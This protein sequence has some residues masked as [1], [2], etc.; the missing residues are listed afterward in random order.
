M[1]P[2][3]RR[4]GYA[5]LWTTVVMACFAV[6]AAAAAPY[7]KAG[8]DLVRYQKT[9]EYIH[10]MMTAAADFETAVSDGAKKPLHNYPGRI[11]QFTHP[12]DS[13]SP[14]SCWNAMTTNGK[15]NDSTTWQSAA[16]FVPFWVPSAGLWTPIG[17][18]RD[19]IP[20]RGSSPNS[21][22]LYVDIEGVTA[23][24]ATGFDMYIDSE[25][26]DTVDVLHPPVNDT[27]TLRIR[28]I[29]TAD[30]NNAC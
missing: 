4:S 17:L 9:A 20:D 6:M 30:A 5:L 10:A 2:I 18:I 26:G 15:V 27:T 12:L 13:S 1:G 3:R 8:T 7:L 24:D 21:N 28:L 14:N 16:P 23:D 11:S 25:S 22:P 29:S 19:S